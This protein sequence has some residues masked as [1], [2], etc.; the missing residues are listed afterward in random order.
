MKPEQSEG[1]PLLL[2]IQCFRVLMDLDERFSLN[3]E[4]PYCR[5]C[6]EEGVRVG[7]LTVKL[8]PLVFTAVE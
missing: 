4:G 6:L 1:G 7:G 5:G 3:S 2:C 8:G